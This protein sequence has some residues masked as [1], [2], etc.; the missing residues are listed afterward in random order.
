MSVFSATSVGAATVASD[1]EAVGAT[2][3]DEGEA[4]GATVASDDEAVGAVTY[5]CGDYEYE[6]TDQFFADGKIQY[7]ARIT[8]YTGE[9][10]QDIVLK[11]PSTLDGYTVKYI[12]GNYNSILNKTDYFKS[13]IIPDTV[14]TI[15]YG[16]LGVFTR[17][18][19]IYLGKNVETVEYF[20]Q[21]CE[22]IYIPKSVITLQLSVPLKALYY[23]G[24]FEDF[25]NISIDNYY[26]NTVSQI[27]Q[28]TYEGNAQICFNCTSVPT[29]GNYRIVS[30]DF[31]LELT[32][33]NDSAEVGEILL[34]AGT[35]E[36]KLELPDGFNTTNGNNN[37]CGYD[38][39]VN[40]STAGGLT[41]STRYKLP[42]KL[43]AT[44]GI[45]KFMYFKDSKALIIRR[46]GELPEVYTVG[47]VN[48][49][50]KHIEGT[51]YYVA[52]NVSVPYNRAFNYYF[53]ICKNGKVL[54]C[55]NAYSCATR[56]TN[57]SEDYSA[58]M[59]AS[60]DYEWYTYSYSL[61]FNSET[62][63]LIGGRDYDTAT[64]VI[65]IYGDMCDSDSSGIIL[66]D[67]ENK[68]NLATATIEL[69]EGAYFFKVYNR[70]VAYGGD[71][72][73][74]DS[75]SRILRNE[76]NSSTLFVASGGT[77]RFIFNKTTGVL[78]IYKWTS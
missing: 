2:V 68:N 40:D 59:V 55:E 63:E 31:N 61:I 15:Y 71:Y 54:G 32:S 28:G 60:T 12:G 45:Y 57:W 52:N 22:Y 7:Y 18:G 13:I 72:V 62:N 46:I 27:Q 30:D 1:D 14:T 75:G 6:K 21:S 78:I 34:E 56:H 20:F 51:S 69:E 39:T 76:F 44:G 3:A 74:N 64:N 17:I 73:I 9:T 67:N 5:T 53:K 36:L 26:L 49:I 8:K 43:N 35:Y 47:D 48:W 29:V 58:S 70:G 11:I 42:I 16:A 66:Y 41:L 19:S 33:K 50:F 10:G 24:S 65:H 77:Y 25:K 37:I 23:E 38:K 4:V